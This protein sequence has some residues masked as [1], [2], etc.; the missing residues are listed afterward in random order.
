MSSTDPLLPPGGSG[1]PLHELR[2][3]NVEVR[4]DP[5][6]LDRLFTVHDGEG[7]TVLLRVAP[8]DLVAI[9]KDLE[10]AISRS[11]N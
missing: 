7:R 8:V 9:L 4:I 10:Q 3:T 6:T 11:L 1:E 2:V 5:C